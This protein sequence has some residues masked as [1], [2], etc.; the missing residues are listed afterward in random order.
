MSSG[1]WLLIE[2]LE[3]WRADERDGFRQFG[4][5][6]GRLKLGKEIKKG[7]MLIFYVSSGI[8]SFA[9]I[10]E[11]LSDG[12]SKLPQGGRY[13]TA[14]PWRVV[15]RPYLSLPREQWVSMKSLADRLSLTAGMTDWRQLLRTSIRRI[16]ATDGD[17]I[18][19]AMQQSAKSGAATL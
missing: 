15:T 12:V 11:A 18:R 13:D 9:D 3:N 5:P 19:A 4:L 16:S 17:L 1:Y 10:R 7:D 6:D 14:F 8:G 2:R